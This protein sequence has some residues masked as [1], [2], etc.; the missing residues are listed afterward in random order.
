[1][2]GIRRTILKDCSNCSE[3]T[4]LHMCLSRN[5]N[6]ILYALR[7]CDMG[8]QTALLAAFKMNE[9]A[10]GMKQ[11]AGN[12]KPQ[13][14]PACEAAAAGVRLIQADVRSIKMAGKR[15]S[16]QINN[17]LDYTEIVEGTLTSIKEP[18]MIT[19]QAW[20][21]QGATYKLLQRYQKG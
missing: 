17:M 16:N 10:H 7:N 2:K 12:R 9:A 5:P 6:M 14:Q 4:R 18:Y 3:I 15:L 8:L 21:K 19:F 1:M 20:R 13:P 11:A